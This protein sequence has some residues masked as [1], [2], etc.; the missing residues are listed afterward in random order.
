MDAF[1]YHLSLFAHILTSSSKKCLFT[2]FFNFE[3]KIDRNY[4][5]LLQ[6]LCRL[7]ML[8]RANFWRLKKLEYLIGAFLDGLGQ[9]SQELDVIIVCLFTAPTLTSGLSQFSFPIFVWGEVYIKLEKGF[10]NFIDILIN[11]DQVILNEVSLAEFDPLLSFF[12]FTLELV[13][14]ID[15]MVRL[16]AGI[17]LVLLGGCRCFFTS[18]RN[19]IDTVLDQVLHDFIGKLVN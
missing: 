7:E 18:W 13:D 15:I 1:P 19:I 5:V 6:V 8:I 12:F 16:A 3:V 10:N 4:W 11:S 17:R 2:R 14:V 9:L